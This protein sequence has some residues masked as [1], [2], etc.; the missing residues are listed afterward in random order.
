MSAKHKTR[1]SSRAP[2]GKAWFEL[3][4][5]GLYGR[6]LA[7][8][9]SPARTMCQARL[10]R[11]VLAARKGGRILDCPCGQGRLTIPLAKM[12]MKMTGVDL[13]PSYIRKAKA[14]ARA[15]RIDARFFQG[16]MR[17]LPF[18]GEFDAVINWFSS[19]GYFDDAGNLA[20][21]R[22]ALAALKPGGQFLVE[23]LNKSHL[24]GHLHSGHEEMINGVR[25]VNYPKWDTKTQ[26]IRDEW[27]MS[28]GRRVERHVIRMRVFNG[29]ELRALLKKAGFTEIR[30]FDHSA[31]GAGRFSSHSRRFIA[32]GRKPFTVSV[33]RK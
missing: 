26:R 23:V 31:A 3:F 29:G 14:R 6:I 10:I 32:I 12:G 5:S 33:E 21:A 2:S 19:F 17:K 28:M 15:A 13:T 22:A 4:F 7:G 11:K 30:L 20:A 16:D 9:I 25:L 8:Q 27:N 24:L 18:A 1:D